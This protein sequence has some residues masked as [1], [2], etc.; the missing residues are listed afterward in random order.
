MGPR[1]CDFLHGVRPL[2][3]SHDR[4]LEDSSR[5]VIQFQMTRQALSVLALPYFQPREE[6]E[7]HVLRS[8]KD[9]RVGVE[10]SSDR[11]EIGAGSFFNKLFK[12]LS[13]LDQTSDGQDYL[14]MD[15]FKKNVEPVGMNADKLV[16]EGQEGHHRV[17][18]RVLREI[19][20]RWKVCE[21]TRVMH[22]LG[23]W[24]VLR[25]EK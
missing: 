8:L 11:S 21:D 12:I 15:T 10:A 4:S 5:L 22:V 23:L 6:G 16:G 18:H 19:S 20:S 13:G 14:E 7:L 1:A 3:L 17:C 24:T 9:S 2:A 25:E